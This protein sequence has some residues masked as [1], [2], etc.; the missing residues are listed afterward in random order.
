MVYNKLSTGRTL[1]DGVG[2]INCL[3]YSETFLILKN[4]NTALVPPSTIIMLLNGFRLDDSLNHRVKEQEVV[5]L[6][7]GSSALFPKLTLEQDQH[8]RAGTN[9]IHPQEKH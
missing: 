2:S 6:L 4:V 3:G 7:A 8:H 9:T 5:N 1:E